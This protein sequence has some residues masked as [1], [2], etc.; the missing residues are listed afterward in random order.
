MSKTTFVSDIT[1]NQHEVNDLFVVTKKGTYTAKNNTKYMMI[2]LKDATGSIEGRVWER[3]DELEGLFEKGDIVSIRSKARLYQDRLQL[4]ITDIRKLDADLA[5]SDIAHFYPSGSKERSCLEKE[6]AEIVEEIGNPWLKELLR[7]FHD[8]A[9]LRDRFFS[10]PAST[11]VHHV[12]VG[13]LL[14]HSLSVARMGMAAASLIGGDRDIIITGSI[15]HDIGKTQELDITRGFRF[16]DRGRL[17]G[18]ITLGVM[19]LED[20]IR[21]IDGFPQELIDILT[22]IIVSHHGLEEWGSPKKPMFP[23]AII[24]HHLDNLDSKVMGVKEHMKD[25]MADERWSEYHRLYEAKYY[26]IN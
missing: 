14:D 15:L 23:E 10:Y 8:D 17:L 26:K 2:G 19:I 7:V 22:H 25:N 13:G 12:Y 18:H 4:H 6:H 3:V 24:V 1:G 9:Q 20:M 11:T 21:R 16:T 5:V